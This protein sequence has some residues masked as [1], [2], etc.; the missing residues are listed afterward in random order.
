MYKIDK[1]KKENKRNEPFATHII[2]IFPTF[3]ANA[4]AGCCCV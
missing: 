4:G 3:A 1:Q 2:N